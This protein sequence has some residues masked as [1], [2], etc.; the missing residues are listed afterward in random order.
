MQE[1]VKPRAL[2]HV[3]SNVPVVVDR[4]VKVNVRNYVLR[5]VFWNARI[6][7]I[8]HVGVHAL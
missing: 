4:P 1:D 7:A 5:T 6:N 8:P 2:L 3:S